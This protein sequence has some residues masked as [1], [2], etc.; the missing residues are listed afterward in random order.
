VAGD[1]RLRI[2]SGTFGVKHA[3]FQSNPVAGITI[4]HES[5]SDFQGGALEKMCFFLAYL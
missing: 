1:W 4:C 5:G 3:Q 2:P